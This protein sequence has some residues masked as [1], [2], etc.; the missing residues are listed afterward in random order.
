LELD[1]VSTKETTGK[2]CFV[3]SPIGN[4]DSEDRIH[5]DWLLDEIVRPVFADRSD[6]VVK[7]GDQFS[8]P[9][10]IDSQVIDA[11]LNSELVIAD[12]S[13]LNPNV[14]YEIGIRHMAQKPIIHMHIAGGDRIPFDVSLFRTIEFSRL[15]PRDLEVARARLQEA[16]SAVLADGYEVDN[17][18]TKA[19]GRL[20]FAEHA[21]PEQQIIADRLESI[22]RR[23]VG[24][25][26]DHSSSL[27]THGTTGN[28]ALEI[29][30]PPSASTEE[31]A[32]KLREFARR[33]NFANVTIS[34][35]PAGFQGGIVY[36]YPLGDQDSAIVRSYLDA[37][38][39]DAEIRNIEF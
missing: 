30:I 11:L 35:G 10:L 38:F 37:R 22:E 8:E 18:V 31:L 1:R 9:G 15:R 27:Y 3:V 33:Q 24:I 5:A 21:T 28:H 14:F 19:R 17:P 32:K 2:L 13:T 39:P 36:L 26:R 6:F 4:D 12:L 34:F 23:L 29:R 20:Q 16:V 7:R 25:E